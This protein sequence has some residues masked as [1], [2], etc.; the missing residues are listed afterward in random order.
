VAAHSGFQRADPYRP[1][2]SHNAVFS[3]GVPRSPP[4]LLLFPGTPCRDG[5]LFM[6]AFYGHKAR[7]A[8]P[9]PESTS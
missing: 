3:R 8:S 5:P 9:F 4:H 2:A 1:S 6:A 7:G